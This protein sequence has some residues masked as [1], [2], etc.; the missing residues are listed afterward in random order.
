MFQN[1]DHALS[2]S[3]ISPI[4][5]PTACS[6]FTRLSQSRSLGFLVWFHSL[7]LRARTIALRAHSRATRSKARLVSKSMVLLATSCW[8]PLAQEDQFY[9]YQKV[10]LRNS[11]CFSILRQSQLMTVN[12]PKVCP[13]ISLTSLQFL[14]LRARVNTVAILSFI[15][16]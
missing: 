12:S 9:Q 16:N 13:F 1:C 15:K 2:P 6:G 8:E 10:I 4:L 7:A 5:H 3:P 11:G 14:V